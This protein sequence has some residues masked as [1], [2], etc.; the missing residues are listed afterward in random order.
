MIMVATGSINSIIDGA[1]ATNYIAPD[2]MVSI[3]LFFPIIKLMDALNIMLLG[4][5]Q[6]LCGRF[7][8]KDDFGAAAYDRI[9]LTVTDMTGVVLLSEQVMNF[10]AAHQVDQKRSYYAGL[11]VEEMA[12]NIVEH[13]FEPEK[14]HSIDIRVI[15]APD[16]LLLRLKDDCK[17]FNPKEVQVIFEPEDITHNIGLRLVSGIAKGMQYQNCFGLNVTTIEI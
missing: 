7:M 2:A 4:G 5:S 12:G 15:Y 1:V 3:A 13:G 16:G 14:A 10:C 8:G 9:D 11:C 6:I 17:P